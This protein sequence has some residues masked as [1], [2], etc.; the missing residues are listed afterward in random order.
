MGLTG[1]RV[2]NAQLSS[3]VELANPTIC[4]RLASTPGSTNKILPCSLLQRY[5]QPV[6]RALLLV[7]PSVLGGPLLLSAVIIRIK[8]LL[9]GSCWCCP[10]T[11]LCCPAL[12]AREGAQGSSRSRGLCAKK[13]YLNHL[14]CS[15]PKENCPLEYL[16]L[17][18]SPVS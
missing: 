18:F 4:F 13:T 7:N 17:V 3:A 11:K 5:Q 10:V 15:K 6:S 16:F 12:P 9:C 2:S 8:S 1:L 14:F